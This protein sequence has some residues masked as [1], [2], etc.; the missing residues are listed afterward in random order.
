MPLH[1]FEPRYKLMIGKCLEEKSEFGVVLATREG[2]AR[3]GCTAEILSVVKKYD[4]GRME[5]AT[6][7]RRRFRVAEL[8]E[9]RPYLQ[10]R[11][12][13]LLDE[14]GPF[15]DPETARRLRELYRE[16]ARLALGGEPAELG[17]DE[18]GSLSYR[19][20][21]ALPLELSAKQRLLEER[22]EAERREVLLEALEE[23][24]S[25]ARKLESAR[26]RAGGNGFGR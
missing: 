9:D 10:G 19:I 20:A 26:R 8:F 12:E 7:G 18:N 22:S 25:R 21:A 11:V 5:I 13:F 16:A 3:V 14:A 1:I 23:W 6:V 17:D 4:D 24:L 2:A 15:G